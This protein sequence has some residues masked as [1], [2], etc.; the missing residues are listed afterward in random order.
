MK[1]VYADELVL[2]E[3]NLADLNEEAKKYLGRKLKDHEIDSAIDLLQSS[4][5]EARAMIFSAVFDNLNFSKKSFLK[6]NLLK[7]ESRSNQ[8]FMK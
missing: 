8:A 6:G 3:I 2:F 4:T 7:K 1:D 5:N